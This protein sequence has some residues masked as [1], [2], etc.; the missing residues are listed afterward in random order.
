MRYNSLPLL[1]K[2]FKDEAAPFLKPFSIPVPG[3]PALTLKGV[4]YTPA[5]KNYFYSQ[6]YAKERIVL[7]FT[8][9][10]T[11]SDM[12]SLTQ[13]GRH[14]S[15]AFLVARDGTIYQLFPSGAWS[16][17]LGK[18]IGN[19]EGNRQDKVTIGIEISN[20]GY[21]VPRDGNLETVYSTVKAPD[22][23][24]SLEQKDA[25]VKINTPFRD[26]SYYASY[27]LLQMESTAIL[28]RYLTN[29]YNIPRQFLPEEKRFL[30]TNDVLQFKGIVS[31]INY[32]TSGKW[33]IGPAFDWNKLIADVTRKEFPNQSEKVAQ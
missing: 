8:A 33:D 19:E 20:Y 18:G 6:Q 15:V 17:H 14:V 5:Q 27:T 1:E 11:W 32:R 10:N 26:Q 30:T 23:Y 4:L 2:R 7:H 24:C 21:L 29:K 13:E 12:R 25:Y 22:L 9:G 3:E 16:G 31:H 28:L